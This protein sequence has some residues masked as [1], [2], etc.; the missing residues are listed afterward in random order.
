MSETVVLQVN[1]LPNGKDLRLAFGRIRGKRRVRS[2]LILI[3]INGD[4]KTQI[5]EKA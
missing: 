2:V 1:L 5:E 4:E 3:K